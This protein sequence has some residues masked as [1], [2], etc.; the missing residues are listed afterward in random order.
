MRQKQ[1]SGSWSR[2]RLA[3]VSCGNG[4][5]APSPSRPRYWPPATVAALTS[6]RYCVPFPSTANP[7]PGAGHVPFLHCLVLAKKCCTF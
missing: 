1:V 2:V 5:R 7:V 3:P 6:V 4:G